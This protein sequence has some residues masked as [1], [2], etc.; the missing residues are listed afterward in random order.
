MAFVYAD[1]NEP[2]EGEEEFQVRSQRLELERIDPSDSR[3]QDHSVFRGFKVSCFRRCRGSVS[4]SH[5]GTRRSSGG[6]KGGRTSGCAMVVVVDA[7]I[8]ANG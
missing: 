5:I 6:E 8:A 1:Q 7:S 2:L 3:S 4:S